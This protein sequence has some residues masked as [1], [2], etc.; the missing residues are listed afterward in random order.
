MNRLKKKHKKKFVKSLNNKN[1]KEMEQKWLMDG[2]QNSK[3]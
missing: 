3:N 1:R 2:Q